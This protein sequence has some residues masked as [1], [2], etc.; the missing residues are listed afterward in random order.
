MAVGRSLGHCYQARDFAAHY[1]ENYSLWG[2]FDPSGKP[3]WMLAADDPSQEDTHKIKRV[4]EIR[5]K[6]NSIVHPTHFPHLDSLFRTA[7]RS[8]IP[9]RHVDYRNALGLWR[10]ANPESVV[11]NGPLTL[12]EGKDDGWLYAIESL[13]NTRGRSKGARLAVFCDAEKWH[14]LRAGTTALDWSVAIPWAA[15]RVQTPWDY[16]DRVGWKLPDG[17]TTFAWEAVTATVDMLVNAAWGFPS[18][19]EKTIGT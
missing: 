14:A 11:V 16:Q 18:P 3:V 10:I 6:S 17:K 4:V 15:W 1:A 19:C 9:L 8:K 2:L 5:G 13:Y 12:F 7:N